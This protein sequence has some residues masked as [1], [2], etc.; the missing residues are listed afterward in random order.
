MA[1]CLRE[2]LLKRAQQWKAFQ[3]W[4]VGCSKR[5]LTVDER[6]AWYVSAFDFARA[7]PAR[8]AITDLSEKANEIRRLHARLKYLS[9]IEN[10]V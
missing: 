9:R 10:D 7:L 4:E 1:R 3:D 6:I 8:S 2:N 5:T